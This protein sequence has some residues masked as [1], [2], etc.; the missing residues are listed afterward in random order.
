MEQHETCRMGLDQRHVEIPLHGSLVLSVITPR[1]ERPWTSWCWCVIPVD[2]LSLFFSHVAF[3]HLFVQVLT[4]ALVNR[5]Q[6]QFVWIQRPRALAWRIR[7]TLSH[8]EGGL[9]TPGCWGWFGWVNYFKIL[10]SFL[11]YDAGVHFTVPQPYSSTEPTP[12]VTASASA[13]S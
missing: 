11:N 12:A 9:C 5:S 8:W 7:R 2:T 3:F 4:D 13:P 1:D 6:C 10:C